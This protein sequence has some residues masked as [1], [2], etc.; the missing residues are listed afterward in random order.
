MRRLSALAGCLVASL[1]SVAS[2]AVVS[3]PY[4]N[5]F[6]SSASDFVLTPADRWSL[7]SGA[8]INSTTTIDQAS[9][10]SV[11]VTG[12]GGAPASAKDFRVELDFRWTSINAAN[13]NNTA[14]IGALGTD[15]NF[16][17]GSGGYYLADVQKMGNLRLYRINSNSSLREVVRPAGALTVNQ[18]Y[19]LILEGDYDTVGNLM[20]TL[21]LLDLAD[22]AKNYSISLTSPIAAASVLQGNH[23]AI[24]NRT[25]GNSHTIRVDEFTVVP[26]P[27]SLGLLAIASLLLRRRARC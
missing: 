27:A 6:A 10:A 19:T 16:T 12:L 5:D 3:Y 7:S 22:A 9:S 15:A 8:L 25:G 17:D 13:T 26:E 1:A 14:G 11:Q 23:F 24:R 4:S 18:D 2:A 20:M 21:T